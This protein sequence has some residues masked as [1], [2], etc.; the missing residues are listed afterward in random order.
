[1]VVTRVTYITYV[2]YKDILRSNEKRDYKWKVKF[3]KCRKE[4]PEQHSRTSDAEQ[5]GRL[6]NAKLASS[7]SQWSQFRYS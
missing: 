2:T 4:E 5:C 3:E 7:T 6:G 1:M